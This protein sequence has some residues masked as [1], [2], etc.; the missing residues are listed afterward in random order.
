MQSGQ[1]S[2]D[3]VKW[4]INRMVAIF[5]GFANAHIGHKVTYVCMGA[6]ASASNMY[7]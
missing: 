6:Q 3:C 4:Y 5:L 7:S 1:W 2:L